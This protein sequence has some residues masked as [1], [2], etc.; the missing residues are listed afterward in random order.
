MTKLQ[1]RKKHTSPDG[2]N[3]RLEA[4]RSDDSMQESDI[5][6]D[7]HTERVSEGDFN[8]DSESNSTFSYNNN[9][10]NNTSGSSGELLN[11]TID[12]NRSSSENLDYNSQ[13]QSEL[14]GPQSAFPSK[15]RIVDMDHYFKRLQN[16]Y[17]EHDVNVRNGCNFMHLE[18]TKSI[19]NGLKTKVRIKCSRCDFVKWINLTVD[20]ADTLTLNESVI[21]G[22]IFAGTNFNNLQELFASI[23]L[24][25][26]T[27][28]AFQAIREGKLLSYFEWAALKEME[29]TG[30][31]ESRIAEAAGH[32]I[33]G[34]PY[35]VVVSDGSW[36][37]RAYK[38]S[39]RESLSG[40]ACIIGQ[41]TGKVLYAGIHNK[42]C[43]LCAWYE[44]KKYERFSS[45]PFF[46]NIAQ[47]LKSVSV[48]VWFFTVFTIVSGIGI[49]KSF[50]SSFFSI[51]FSIISNF[52]FALDF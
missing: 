40:M 39:K 6:W 35:I 17:F 11:Y 26:M 22:T 25:F 51:D 31:E 41:K 42:Y 37:N 14:E 52:S 34:V 16:I 5:R 28:K 7:Q 12:I 18:M 44:R 24:P 47:F 48:H 27:A 50:F 8:A 43:S 38:S 36:M 15:R 45:Q 4:S 30:A 23:D 29:D 10:L 19:N 46:Q 33:N 32:V 20:V 9:T 49:Y 21:A 2:H 1:T 13:G 3:D